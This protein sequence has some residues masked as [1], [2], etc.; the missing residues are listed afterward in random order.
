M[1]GIASEIWTVCGAAG[2]CATGAITGMGRD[3]GAPLAMRTGVSRPAAGSA[4]CVPDDDTF[5]PTLFAGAGLPNAGFSESRFSGKAVFAA[6]AVGVAT[7]WVTAG[8]ESG[9]S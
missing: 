8:R 2:C 6:N 3:A 7:R 1:T 9:L 5:A 4:R